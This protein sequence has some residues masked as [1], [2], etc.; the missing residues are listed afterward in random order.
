MG[1][2]QFFLTLVISCLNMAPLM[3]ARMILPLV[4]LQTGAS[5]GFVGLLS[6]MFTAPP[7]VF[8]VVFGRWVDRTGTFRPMLVATLLLA[9]PSLILLFSDASLTFLL[10]AGLIGSGGVFSHIAATR[11]V[12]EISSDLKRARNLGLL[13]AG[14]SIAQFTG[15]T[16]SGLILEHFGQNMAYISI[17]FLSVF[18]FCLLLLPWHAF[19]QWAKHRDATVARSRIRELVRVPGLKRWL[20]V[21]TVTSGA[22]TTFPL[23]VALQSAEIGMSASQAGFS[24]GAFS[25]ATV[26]SR[27]LTGPVS[28]RFPATTAVSSMLAAGAV[29]FVSIAYVETFAPFV[30]TCAALGLVLGMCAP[31]VLSVIYALAPSAR[32]NEVIGL[33]MTLTNTMQTILPLSLGILATGFGTSAISWML[34]GL[35]LG[36]INMSIRS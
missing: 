4:L 20:A 32:V 12:G 16:I 18:G 5:A 7:I 1:L 13:I 10:V 3:T 28:A 22:M 25:I 2:L 19:R 15:P 27:A 30:M 24:L 9:F 34:A 14:Y 17:G 31:F 29:L 26:A 11:A 8:N 6:A 36:A 33:S 35:M 23:I 21:N